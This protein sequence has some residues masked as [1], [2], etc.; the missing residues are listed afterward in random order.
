VLLLIYVAS[1][2]LGQDTLLGIVVGLMWGLGL[3]TL[4][5]IVVGL[6]WGLGQDTLLGI[7][8]GLC[9]ASGSTLYWVLLLVH[10]LRATHFTGHCCWLCCASGNTLYWL[11]LLVYG[12]PR[13]TVIPFGV[14]LSSCVFAKPNQLLSL[15]ICL[16]KRWLFLIKPE[17]LFDLSGFGSAKAKHAA[18]IMGVNNFQAL[19]QSMFQFCLWS[20]D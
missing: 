4:L 17:D 2:R 7:I 10:V 12:G 8:V 5:G 15:I 11:L 18:N 13:T 14:N 16:F 9:G 20:S 6:M 19:T 3:G 1:A